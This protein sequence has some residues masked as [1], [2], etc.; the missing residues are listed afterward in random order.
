VD[1]GL[2]GIGNDTYTNAIA[3]KNL[4]LAALAGRRVGRAPNPAWARVAEGLYLPYDSAGQY[5]P[6]YEGAP[7][8]KR[9][10][11]VPLLA[12]PLALPMSEQAKRND[13][14]SAIRLMIKRGGGAMMTETLYPVIAAELGERALVDT[15]LPLSYEAHVRPPFDA[16][17]ET[18]RND[19]VNFLTGA[20]GFLQQV[21]FGYTGLRLRDDGLQP[22]FRPVL[23]SRIRRLTL[24]RIVRR[25]RV[26]DIVVE[27]DSIRFLAR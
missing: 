23:P 11:V 27:G 17:S 5:H 19:A 6:T 20:G 21:V 26:Y 13:V 16:L 22:V 9:G 18:P 1:E 8:A 3:R 4:E 25:G 7:E 12:F 24:T 15:L 14:E 2:I 10:S